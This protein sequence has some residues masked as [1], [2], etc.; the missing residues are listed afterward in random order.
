MN[1]VVAHVGRETVDNRS[2]PIC[3]TPLPATD[4]LDA[5]VRPLHDGRER[6]S[7]LDIVFGRGGANLPGAVHLV[8]E[9]PVADVIR[10]LV[11]VGAP[12]IGPPRVTRPVAVLD[13][14]L[15][16]VHA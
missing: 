3:P 1:A 6:S 16:L 13:P 2:I 7:F 9:T 11:A 10:G 8:A 12:E 14:G 5:R 15:R 4:E